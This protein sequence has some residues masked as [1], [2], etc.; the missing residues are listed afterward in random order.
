MGAFWHVHLRRMIAIYR[1]INDR[2]R[3]KL[4]NLCLSEDTV[5]QKS[6][7]RLF[8]IR[9]G[10]WHCLLNGAYNRVLLTLLTIVGSIMTLWQTAAFFMR[11][12]HQT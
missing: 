2:F 5:K 6:N 10:L 4:L 12:C 9:D 8:E 1:C 7:K 3:L 11:C